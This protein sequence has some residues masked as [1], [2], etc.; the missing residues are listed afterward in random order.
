[1]YLNQFPT[2]GDVQEGYVDV[3]WIVHDGGLLLMIAHLLKQ[4]RIWRKCKL[5][6]HVVSEKFHDPV[7]VKKTMEKML[8][9]VCPFRMVDNFS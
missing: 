7:A 8:D 1:M 2:N 3:W 4:H 6:V 9:K 5:R